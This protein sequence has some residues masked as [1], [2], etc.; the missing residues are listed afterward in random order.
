MTLSQLR[1]RIDQL[2][3]R[4]LALLNQRAHLAL[5]VGL[6][7]RRQDRQLFDPKRE[8]DIL[9]QVAHANAGPLSTH[10]VRAIYREILRQ[11]RRLEQSV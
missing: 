9:R 2:D 1:K 7:K 10:A 5:R 6:L 4:L 8:R 11:I 3:R